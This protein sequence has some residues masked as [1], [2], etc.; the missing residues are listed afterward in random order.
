[1]YFFEIFRIFLSITILLYC[2]NIRDAQ[3]TYYFNQSWKV[4]LQYIDC[5]SYCIDNGF[6]WNFSSFVICFKCA[7]TYLHSTHII[8][9][10]LRAYFCNVFKIEYTFRRL[11]R[12][13]HSWSDYMSSVLAYDTYECPYIYMRRNAKSLLSRTKLKDKITRI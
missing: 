7:Y 1:M 2:I 4:R 5:G 13:R 12:R 8:C 9:T 3:Y 6:G 11:F 10:Y